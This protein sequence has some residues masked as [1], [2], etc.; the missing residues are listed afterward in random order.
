M[1]LPINPPFNVEFEAIYDDELLP[2]SRTGDGFSNVVQSN[3]YNQANIRLWDTNVR[4]SHVQQ[5]NFTIEQLLPFDSVFSVGYVGQKGTHLVVPMPY[6][7]RVDESGR[8]AACKCSPYLAG[9]PELK[10]I[11]QISGTESNG[12]QEYNSLQASLKRRA[13]N[14]LQYQLS[15]TWSKGMSDA[16]GYY[17]SGGLPRSQSA[18]WQNLRDQRAEWGPTFFDQTHILVANFVYMLPVGKDR[19]IGRNWGSAAETLL[20]GWQVSGIVSAKS[21]MPWTIRSP[22][23]SGTG[24]RGARADRIGDGK[25]PQEVGPGTSWLDTSAYAIPVRGTFGTA[26]VGTVRG[27][28]YNTVDLSLEKSFRIA[29]NHRLQIRADFV[30]A[31]NSPIFNGGQR[32]VNNSA[33]GEIT[34]AQGS[35]RVQ[36]AIRYEF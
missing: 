6:H 36:L 2:V 10:V 11:S 16:I 31:F 25:G 30:G 4:P 20:G 15:Y 5:W 28:G 19:A 22:E 34:G 23:R 9:N 1:R 29:E 14:S 18:Y 7:Q 12:N 3:P 21:G 17:G 24:S 13:S 32:S 26:G 8:P 27:P 35:R 33:F